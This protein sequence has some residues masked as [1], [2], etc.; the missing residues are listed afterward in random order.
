MTM[1]I[2]IH[3]KFKKKKFTSLV[4]F[5]L[6]TSP[7]PLDDLDLWYQDTTDYSE[8]TSTMLSIR[9]SVYYFFSWK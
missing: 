9:C 3:A 5:A 6:F 7:P 1:G 4:P 8:V 2:Y